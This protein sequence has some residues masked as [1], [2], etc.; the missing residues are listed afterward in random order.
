MLN[1]QFRDTGYL[2]SQ[3][4]KTA[5]NEDSYAVLMEIRFKIAIKQWVCI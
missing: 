3:N 1:P 4:P 5:K 2:N